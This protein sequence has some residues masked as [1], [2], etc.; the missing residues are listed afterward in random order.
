[1]LA[2]VP[3]DHFCHQT[4]HGASLPPRKPQERA[5]SQL[6]LDLMGWSAPVLTRMW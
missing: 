1:V 6:L 5:Q 4:V 2:D 3:L